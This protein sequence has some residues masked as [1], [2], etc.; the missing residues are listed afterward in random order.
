M[1]TRTDR[2]EDQAAAWLLRQ[3]EADWSAATQAELDLWL[4][5][6]TEHRVTFIRLRHGWRRADRLVVGEPREAPPVVHP[7]PRRKPRRAIN[8]AWPAVGAL[9]AASIAVGLFVNHTRGRTYVTDI[10]GHASA[11]LSD[12]TRVELNTDTRLRAAVDG[13]KRRVWLDQGE[14]YFEVAHDPSRPFVID[15]GARRITVLGTKFS[16]RRYPD[17]RVTVAVVEGRVRVEGEGPEARPPVL[18]VRGDVAQ[19]DGVNTLV[20]EVA[21]ERIAERIAWRTGSLHFEEA[22]LAEAVEEFN[23]YNTKKLVIADKAAGEIRI[24]GSFEATDAVAFARLLRRAF[25]LKVEDNGQ[26]I[27][28]SS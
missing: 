11:P 1:T 7:A 10:G 14:A 27:L 2:I 19:S 24:G 5:A 20:S 17:G 25:S 21:P 15:A 28:I 26:E 16:V 4:E 12:G 6:D 3:E 13:G 22:T 9:M 18:I 8:R 23:R